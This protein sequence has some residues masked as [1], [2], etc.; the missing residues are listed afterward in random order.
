MSPKGYSA[1]Q[2]GLHWIVAALIVV[3]LVF[4]DLIK[5]GWRAIEQGGAPIYDTG[6]LAHIG[7]GVAVLAFAIWRLVLR[8]T[9][10]VPDAPAGVSPAVRLAG[11]AGHVALYALMIGV[12]VIGLLAWFGASEDLAELHELGKPLFIL[13]IL[14]HVGAALWHQFIRKDGLMNRMRKA[15]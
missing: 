1:L 5:T 15:G 10:G 3:N 9:R 14:A 7:I 8:F 12:P 13:F 2:I 6:A 11:H 4:E